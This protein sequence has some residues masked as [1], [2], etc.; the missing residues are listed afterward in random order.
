M[1]E[2]IIFVTL[3]GSVLAGLWDL[4]TTE[5]PDEIPAIIIVFSLAAGAINFIITGDFF[6]L[7]ISII[8]GTGLLVAGLLIY[9]RKQWGAADAWM[10]GAIGYGIPIAGFVISYLF[11]FLIV[12]M[13][14]MIIYALALGFRNRETFS[15]FAADIKKN[16][17]YVV[18]IPVIFLVVTSPL[19]FIA[20]DITPLILTFLLVVFL[21]FF[22]RYAKVVENSVFRKKIRAKDIKE[23]DVLDGGLVTGLTKEE[24]IA[25]RKKRGYVTIKDGVRFVPVFPITLA[26]T[27]IY[28][29]LM[30]YFL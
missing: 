10:L 26:I 29:N 21:A 20:S 12:A 14:Y 30:F 8:G 22:W 5:V 27:L 16:Y 28:G 13:A 17:R 4:K 15:L 2:L 19:L 11:N 1:L 24:V 7:L 18:L 9:Y 6:P 23:G 25:L 3:A